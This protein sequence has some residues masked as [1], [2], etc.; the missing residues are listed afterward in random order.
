[1]ITRARISA[2]RASG[3]R[4]FL[5]Q[6]RRLIEGGAYSSSIW[7]S[8]KKKKASAIY[9][10]AAENDISTRVKKKKSTLIFVVSIQLNMKHIKQVD[11]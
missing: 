7:S 5:S 1:M 11:L 4:R 8:R 2:V 6:M 10:P 3:V 9:S